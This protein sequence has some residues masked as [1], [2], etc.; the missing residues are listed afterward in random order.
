MEGE[1]AEPP[2][3]LSKA[4]I[5]CRNRKTQCDAPLHGLPCSNCTR[6][7]CH[8]RCIL[9]TRKRREINLAKKAQDST[10]IRPSPTNIRPVQPENDQ[11]SGP[12]NDKPSDGLPVHSSVESTIVATTNALAKQSDKCRDPTKYQ[13]GLNYLGILSQVEEDAKHKGHGSDSL[14]TLVDGSPTSA[15]NSHISLGYSSVVSRQLD[16]ADQAFLVGKG[17]FDLPPQHCIEAL[18]RAYFDFVDPFAPIL[19]RVSFVRSFKSGCYSLFLMHATL[20]SGALH[21]SPNIIS[22][23][24]FGG[25][26]EAQASFSSRATLLYDFQCETNSLHLLQG[27]LLLGAV[28]ITSIIDKDCHYWLYNSVRLITRTE[29]HRNVTSE[30]KDRNLS[31]LY[32]RIWWT[33][34][35][36]DVHFTVIGVQRTSLVSQLKCNITPLTAQDWDAEN[37]PEDFTSIL[38]PVTNRQISAFISYCQLAVTVNQCLSDHHDRDPQCMVEPLEAWRISLRETLQMNGQLHQLDM[39]SSF[40]LASSYRFE[41][42][43]LRLLRPRWQSLDPARRELARRQLRFA[44]FELDTITGR[45]LACN[46]LLEAPVAFCT[47]IPILLALHVETV[48]DTTES[49]VNQSIS[50][51]SISRVMLILKHM[52]EIP[53]IQQVLP[54]FEQVLAKYNLTS[55]PANAASSSIV[56][57]EWEPAPSEQGYD[58]GWRGG[59]P[60]TGWQDLAEFDVP[61]LGD[62]SIFESLF[63]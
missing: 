58:A 24:G 47:C 25:R 23:C 20:A 18:L 50:R 2:V 35:F 49:E 44:M 26:L 57:T 6:K 33:L 21:V 5:P 63:A 4:C 7:S 42:I 52:A 45:M 54:I 30:G 55:C 19:D 43:L 56:N 62:F 14:T 1:K 27:S 29:L 48:L 17:V 38:K 10:R 22:E 40:L 8:D 36:R 3:K 16:A 15:S 39:T 32:R 46:T 28:V 41:C 13:I 37:I 12:P 60:M 51:I 9:P 34:Y 61:M 53:S 59:F 31:K 11:A